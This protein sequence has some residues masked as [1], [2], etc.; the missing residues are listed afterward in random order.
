MRPL[1][2]SP[3]GKGRL[4][5][6]GL[7]RAPRD[8][9]GNTGN[10]RVCRF[11]FCTHLDSVSLLAMMLGKRFGGFLAAAC[12]TSMLLGCEEKPK[13]TPPA[14]KPSTVAPTLP[15]VVP[16]PPQAAPKPAPKPKKTAADCPKSTTVSFPNADF[17][18][19]VR[20]KLQKK[21]GDVTLAELIKVRSLNVS[22]SKLDE[23][24]VCIFPHMKEL[25]ELFIGPGQV[26]D[27]SALATLTKLESLRLS[28]NPIRDLK[29]LAEMKKLDR[30]DLAHTEVRD[31][32]PLKG[33]TNLTEL[34]L[35][36]TPVDDVS[37]LASLEKLSVLVLKNTRVKDVKP[38]R[39]L[40]ALKT[41]DLRGAP[42]DDSTSIA[43][44]GL[45]IDE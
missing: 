4:L 41:L 34:L 10:W 36:D 32:T 38:L 30:L 45:R 22:Q 11:M 33:L 1:P 18:G 21:T 43:R 17:E 2:R 5:L 13:P 19:A 14:P 23:L 28:L 26:E 27:I 9:P 6:L 3:A 8:L 35:D 29:P 39:A 37:P 44:P 7:G 24:D 16:A 31:L 40:K 20:L 15:S 12:L 42:V 25:H